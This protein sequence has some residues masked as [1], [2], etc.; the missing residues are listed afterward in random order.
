[1]IPVSAHQA[2]MQTGRAVI[3]DT[4]LNSIADRNKLEGPCS[5]HLE[6]L[7]D[8]ERVACAHMVSLFKQKRYFEVLRYICPRLEAILRAFYAAKHGHAMDLLLLLD[9]TNKPL[10]V[11]SVLD[12]LIELDLPYSVSS[13]LQSWFEPPTEG[14]S[15]PP[16]Y[17]FALIKIL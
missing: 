12:I 7:L 10:T 5:L 15:S 9:D 16:S 3:E 14:F 1:M 11:P 8:M 6:S 4:M 2:L 17:I 13:V